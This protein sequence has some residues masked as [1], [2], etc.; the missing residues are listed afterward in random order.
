VKRVA[1]RGLGTIESKRG[2]QRVYRPVPAPARSAPAARAPVGPVGEVA[3]EAG[4]IGEE[5]GGV[6]ASVRQLAWGF[7]DL[8]TLETRRAG[9]TLM[10]MAAWSAVAAILVISA[11]LALMAMAA[12]AAVA[13]G[14]AWW[15]ALAAI[16][17]VNVALAA[18]LM[19]GVNASISRNLLFP[20]TR[21]QLARRLASEGEDE[22]GDQ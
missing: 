13:L 22:P 10:W 12:L 16:A 8:V 9:V 17:V 11:W 14:M 7:V 4:T 18:A 20:A 2:T 19:F 21:R 3:P 15:Q 6:F 1:R 5:L